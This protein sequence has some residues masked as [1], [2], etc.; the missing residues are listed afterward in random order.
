MSTVVKTCEYAM[1]CYSPQRE[2][3]KKREFHLRLSVSVC[4]CY[5]KFIEVV[6]IVGCLLLDVS[7]CDVC[8]P[9]PNKLVGCC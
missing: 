9:T 7:M 6:I 5:Y 4:V 3:D 2:E 1:H 8:L